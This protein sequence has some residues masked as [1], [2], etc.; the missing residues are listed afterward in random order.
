M[1]KLRKNSMW[2]SSC[3]GWDGI[4]G[5]YCVCTG[6]VLPNGGG[7]INFKVWYVG[8]SKNIGKRLMNNNHPYKIL[9]SKGYMPFIRYIETTNYVKI[10]KRVVRL[11]NPPMNKQHRRIVFN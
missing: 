9:F 5:V 1:R 4:G 3:F 6:D 8:S 10:E 2:Q 11:L 7:M